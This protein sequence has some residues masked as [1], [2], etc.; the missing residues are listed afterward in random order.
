MPTNA[1]LQY[2]IYVAI[3]LGGMIASGGMIALIVFLVK[4]LRKHEDDKPLTF[5]EELRATM[6]PTGR[7]VMICGRQGIGKGAL[8]TA[9]MDTDATYH[10]AERFGLALDVVERINEVDDYDLDVPSFMYRSKSPM[11][12]TPNNIPTYH[13]DVSQFALPASD[14]DDTVQYFPPYTLIH[15]DE[16]DAFMNTRTWN[17]NKNKKANIIDAYKWLRHNDLTVIGDAQVFGRL[18]NALRALTTDI[19]YIIDRKD[20]YANDKKR[21]W[22]QFGKKHNG[23]I[24]R[25]EWTFL[26]INNQVNQQAEEFARFGEIIPQENCVKRCKFNYYGNIY[27]RYNSKSGRPYWYRGIKRYDVEFHPSESLKKED[28]KDF[29]ERNARNSDTDKGGEN[30]EKQASPSNRV[31]P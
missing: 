2:L 4:K 13:T 12:L 14:N 17:D 30:A 27:E 24:E 1:F 19:F 18:D 22:W 15:F 16:I 29:C 3:T 10:A 26:W 23:G 31:S 21:K 9:I 28:V 7:F 8:G 25:T 6:F 11:W 5:D 20:F